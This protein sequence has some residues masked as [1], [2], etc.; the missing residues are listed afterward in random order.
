[1]KKNRSFNFYYFIFMVCIVASIF[2]SFMIF[3]KK[4]SAPFW[5]LSIFLVAFGSLVFNTG[6]LANANKEINE[7][8][9]RRAERN[10][11]SNRYL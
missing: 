1:M 2:C 9:Q 8:R 11:H 10:S 3:S 4:L 5:F 7:R 6:N